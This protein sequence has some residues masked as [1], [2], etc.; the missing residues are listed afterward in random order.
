MLIRFE[1]ENYRSIK[2]P[3]VFHMVQRN[4]KRFSHH[5]HNHSDDLKI[6]KTSGVYGGNATGKTNLFRGLHFVKKMVEEREYLTSF[7]STKY[8]H[9]FLLDEQSKEKPSKFQVD[10]ISKGEIFIYELEVN[11]SSKIVLF[12]QLSKSKNNELELIFKRHYNESNQLKI[13]YPKKEYVVKVLEEYLS[14]MKHSSLISLHFFEEE[15]LEKARD[16]FINKTEFLFPV[17]KFMDIAYI[18]SLKPYYLEIA[19]RIIKFSN[20]GIDKLNIE[21]IPLKIYLGV[22]NS[23]LIKHVTRNLEEQDYFSF[24]DSNGNECTAIKENDRDISVLKLVAIHIS[25]NGKEVP[26]DLEQESRG[27]LVLIHLLPALILSYGE[28]VNYFIDEINR[29]LHPILFKELLKQYLDNNI[30]NASGQLIF[31]SHEDF[32][33]DEKVI[34]QDELWLMDKIKNESELFPLS[35][36]PN[37]RFDLNYRKNYLNGKFG[38]VPFNKKPSK[39]IFSE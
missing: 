11:S 29:S 26:F 37:V 6:L 15:N 27:T 23:D 1:L 36:F 8:F 17:Y 7:Q 21:K 10:F 32:M 35:D 12:E 24:Q 28:G 13:E 19:N 4:Y 30:E 31:N 14:S 9:P 3:L 22:D 5:V 39:L 33:M 2:K 34:R 38:G 25:N 18:L 16:W 20:T